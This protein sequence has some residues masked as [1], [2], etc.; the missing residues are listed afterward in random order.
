MG[1]RYFH[2]ASKISVGAG[3]MVG[4]ILNKRHASSHSRNNAM[5]KAS[6]GSTRLMKISRFISR[7]PICHRGHRVHRGISRSDA[8][9]GIQL[10]DVAFVT[11]RFFS[12]ISVHSVAKMFL[13]SV[14]PANQRAQ[15]MHDSLK[16]R[17]VSDIQITRARQVHLAAFKDATGAVG[18]HVYR[19]GEE[20]R[21]A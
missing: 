8:F 7:T 3:R 14:L 11:N 17:G 18:H 1:L 6:G 15:F 2:S 5:V 9:L 10:M 16:R 13:L 20:Y 12:V 19:V 21:L 4:G